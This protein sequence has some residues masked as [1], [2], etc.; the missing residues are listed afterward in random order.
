MT[1]EKDLIEVTLKMPRERN[2]E[3]PIE[4]YFSAIGFRLFDAV[5]SPDEDQGWV[6]VLFFKKRES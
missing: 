2:L 4:K 5:R 3:K 6:V 1:K